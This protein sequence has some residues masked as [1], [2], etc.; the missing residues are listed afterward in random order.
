MSTE[1]RTLWH[2]TSGE[3][4]MGIVQG[5]SIW[6]THAL[7]LNDSAEIAWGLSAVHDALTKAGLEGH[8]E[9][10]R[11]AANYI[12]AASSD[13]W[14]LEPTYVFSL[15]EESDSLSQWRGYTKPGDGYS[16]GFDVSWLSE[17]AK[18]TQGAWNLARCVYTA[19]EVA[20]LV[21]T[22]IADVRSDTAGAS[23]AECGQNLAS[24]LLSLVP[25]VKHPA[26]EAEHEWRL[27][28][29]TPAPQVKLRRGTN[30][31]TPYVDVH[32]I[33]SK[34]NQGELEVSVVIGPGPAT[35]RSLAAVST[36]MTGG[37]RRSIRDVRV[38]HIPYRTW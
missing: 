30:S 38:S 22:A 8:D 10:A 6:A 11:M 27:V 18:S 9:C 23:D 37:E 15:S 25:L 33:W 20:S 31:L 34:D 2:Y 24:K 35:E 1:P 3:G 12:D 7:F 14:S 16:I 29:G 17:R 36:F 4:L 26:F 28:V 5:G 21:A 19:K 13:L 32:L